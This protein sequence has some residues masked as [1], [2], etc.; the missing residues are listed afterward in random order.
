M[1]KIL[2]MFFLFINTVL[3]QGW[4]QTA[5]RFIDDFGF[6]IH[7]TTDG[8]YSMTG[9]T[10]FFGNGKTTDIWLIKTDSMGNQKWNQTFTDSMTANNQDS[11]IYQTTDGGYF[12]TGETF[13]DSLTAD[14]QDSYIHYTTDGGYIITGETVKNDIVNVWLI[15]IDSTGDEEWNLTFGG[16][17]D[18][19][20]GYVQQTSD[21]GYIITGNTSSIGDSEK[22]IWLIKTDSNG[23]EEWNKTFGSS[24]SDIYRSVH[25]TADGGYIITGWTYSFENGSSNVWLIKTDSNGNEKW[26]HTFGGQLD[27]EGVSVQL[28]IDGGY[29]ITGYTQSSGNSE[30]NFW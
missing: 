2:L 18:D 1:K 12:L 26:N 21:D 23:N 17:S 24:D 10:I 9:Y 20:R 16:S 29:I 22:D 30:E 25:Q 4:T 7:Q 14:D 11:S 27:G 19:D 6:S 15:K 28:T 13:T 8:G 3:G 5:G